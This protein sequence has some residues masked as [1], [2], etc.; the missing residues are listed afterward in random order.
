M[1]LEFDKAHSRDSAYRVIAWHI[2]SRPLSIVVDLVHDG[3]RGGCT[4][5]GR[6]IENRFELHFW[7][8]FFNL[9]ISA[10][11]N[12]SN[13]RGYTFAMGNLSSYV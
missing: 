2:N 7:D 12:G 10:V 11:G 5:G 3:V 1:M 9:D 4:Y 8:G 6:R 13:L